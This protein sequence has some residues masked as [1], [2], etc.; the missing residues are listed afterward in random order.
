MKT[1]LRL[2]AIILS[3]V[4]ILAAV[5]CSKNNEIEAFNA[6]LGFLPLTS[7]GDGLLTY[8]P[9]RGFRSGTGFSLGALAELGTRE[10]ITD[11]VFKNLDNYVF[12]LKDNTKVINLGYSLTDFNKTEKLP[13]EALLAFRVVGD[14]LRQKGYKQSVNFVYNSSYHVAWTTSEEARKNTESVCASEDI[15]LAHIEQLAPV[16]SE[17]KDTLFSVMG[18]FIGFSG[19]M[20]ESSQY[21]PVNRNTIM[22][23]V[24]EKLA[25]PNNV[26]YLIRTPAH[27]EELAKEFPDYE[28][29]DKISFVNKS[30]FGEQTKLGWHSGGFQKGNPEKFE[31]DWWEYVTDNA[32]YAPNDG[33][34]FPNRNLIGKQSYPSPRIMTGLEIILE[35][36]HHGMTTMG[37]WNGYYEVNRAT[38][39][40]AVMDLW[41]QQ[42][43]TPEILD[44]NRI[45][46]D[47]AWF[48]DD[49]G[50]AVWRNTF[51]F[52]RDHLGYKLSAVS[53]SVGSD[54]ENV[55]VSLTLKNYGFSAAFNLESGFAILD[56][57]YNEITSVKAGE[58][59][60][61]YSHDP[62]DYTS[63]KVLEYNISGKLQA[64]IETGKYYVAFYLKNTMNDG[65]MLSN[66]DLAFE[67]GYNILYDF[68]V[69]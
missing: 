49:S 50:S 65:A 22:K 18:G 33:E 1:L 19:D 7:D 11:E 37:I 53:G 59:D 43:I 45:V 28:H 68:T 13:E 61:W 31:V 10:K 25:V 64:P 23:A 66:R 58:P 26:Y 32:L 20:A 40:P 62:K 48:T 51:E 9:D 15:M 4:I 44:E 54:G 56:E 52:I 46:Y 63:T 17:Y 41:Q 47:P 14:I 8:N 34:V 3:L 2:T 69:Q 38:E 36:A 24:I 55:D 60:K 39:S 30:M 27:K 67:N 5:G 42:E 6:D 12:K 16:L 21:P 29:L 35:C 57:N